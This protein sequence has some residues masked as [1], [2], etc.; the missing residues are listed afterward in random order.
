MTPE[1]MQTR[2]EKLEALAAQADK[3]AYFAAKYL[4]ELAD[5]V[6]AGAGNTAATGVLDGLDKN[7][8][9]LK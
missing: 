8:G 4:R 6:A 9:R 2:I 5:G 1:E 7:L 3:R